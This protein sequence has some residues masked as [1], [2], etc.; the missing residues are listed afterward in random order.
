MYI[1]GRGV[2]VDRHKITRTQTVRCRAQAL[3]SLCESVS[4]NS[5]II[6]PEYW[7]IKSVGQKVL[8]LI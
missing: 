6:Q 5:A 8:S 1:V 4:L 3:N 2:V 7:H